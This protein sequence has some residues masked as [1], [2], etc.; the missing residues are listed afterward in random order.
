[1]HFEVRRFDVPIDPMPY[2]L[3]GTAA[4]NTATTPVGGA[5][6]C[7]PGSGGKN[8]AAAARGPRRIARA[9]LAGC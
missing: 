9:R 2:L 6:D 8:H 4:R 7:G 5:L 3:A 1:V